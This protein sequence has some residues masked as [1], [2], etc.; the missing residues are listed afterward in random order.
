MFDPALLL[1]S[2]NNASHGW[3][4]RGRHVHTHTE[5]RPSVGDEGPEG[6][7][8]QHEARTYQLK[9]DPLDLHIVMT[10]EHEAGALEVI[11]VMYEGTNIDVTSPALM[12]KLDEMAAA[13]LAAAESALASRLA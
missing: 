4:M 9:S 6:Y 12:A 11:W 10:S 5:Y 2:L 13:A 8:V 7:E 3:I 1:A